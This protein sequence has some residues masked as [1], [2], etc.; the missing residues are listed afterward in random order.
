MAQRIGQCNQKELQ[1]Q[2]FLTCVDDGPDE[3]AVLKI[4]AAATTSFN[5]ATAH[6]N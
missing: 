5:V 3:D 6:P 1:G 4:C 2:L